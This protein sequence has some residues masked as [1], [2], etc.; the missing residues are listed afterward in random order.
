MLYYIVFMFF[1]LVTLKLTYIKQKMSFMLDVINSKASKV[2]SRGNISQ[3]NLV[4]YFQWYICPETFLFK[5]FSQLHQDV[6]YCVMRSV[7]ISSNR[8]KRNLIYDCQ[9]A[10]QF[11]LKINLSVF[12][13]SLVIFV[14]LFKACSSILSSSLLTSTR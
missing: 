9:F 11:L 1:Q 4:P 13:N 2:Y 6:A 3:V 8:S 14:F 12:S 7:H 10:L 5:K